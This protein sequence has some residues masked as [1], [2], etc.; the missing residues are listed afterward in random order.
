MQQPDL[1][2]P[3]FGMKPLHIFTQ[4]LKDVTVVCRIDCLACRDKFFVKNPRYGKG[5]YEHALDFALRLHC[6]FQS[7]LNRACHSNTHVRL[8]LSSLNA[9]L[10]ITRVTVALFPRFAQYLMLTRVVSIA[11]FHQA[12]EITP[13][14]A[15]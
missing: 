4:A 2:S 3:N 8:M 13:N 6:I 11:K 12:K 14:K 5:N 15:A 10:I 1:L 9:C 7:S